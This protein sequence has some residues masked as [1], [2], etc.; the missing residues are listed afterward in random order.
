M[1]FSGN[2]TKYGT[3]IYADIRMDWDTYHSRHLG[4]IVFM[5][6]DQSVDLSTTHWSPYL[7]PYIVTQGNGP[8]VNGHPVF[9]FFFGLFFTKESGRSSAVIRPVY[10]PNPLHHTT[11]PRIRSM[12]IHSKKATIQLRAHK[13][14][15]EALYFLLLSLISYL[16][17]FFSQNLRTSSFFFF[18]FFVN[19]GSHCLPQHVLW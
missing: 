12:L 11:L 8:L 18:F 14:M 1:T 17:L 7:M 6:T 5:M 10:R 3:C 2:C 19:T 16:T 13:R 9:F 15:A 4:M